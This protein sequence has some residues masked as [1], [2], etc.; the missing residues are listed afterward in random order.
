M[1]R[2]LAVILLCTSALITGCANNPLEV[3]KAATE[4]SWQLEKKGDVIAKIK[5]ANLS[6]DELKVITES[7][8]VLKDLQEKYKSVTQD[9][10]YILG[11]II[12]LERDQLDAEV[13]YKNV[14]EI[15]SNHWNEYSIQDQFDFQQLDKSA[16]VLNGE[17]EYFI[18]QV[19]LR[20]LANS[21][22]E[23]TRLGIQLA[24]M[25]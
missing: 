15:V 7:A 13:A 19:N 14:Y 2:V 6:A 20:G 5:T 8:L 21:I 3:V 18:G 17:V 25:L 22:Y 12:T 11:N 10:S 4:A 23:Y 9:P 24:S 16:K 1:N